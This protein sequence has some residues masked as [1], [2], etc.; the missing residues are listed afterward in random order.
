MKNIYIYGKNNIY[1]IY[2]RYPITIQPYKNLLVLRDDLLDGGTK[3]IFMPLIK[4]K[5]IKKYVYA[6]PVEG[7][8][9]L[10]LSKYFKKKCVIFVAKRKKIHDNQKEV[11]KNGSTVIQVPFGYLSNVQAKAKEYCN[12]NKKCK[13]IEWGG[14]TYIDAIT[15]RAKKVIKKTGKLDE[16]WCAIG[17][18]TLVQGIMKAVPKNTQ[19]YGVQVGAKYRGKK[20]KNLHII[21]YK[22]P[23]KYES[24]IKLPFQSNKNYDSKVFEIALKKAKGKALLWNVY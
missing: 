7:G 10:A 11:K 2:M 8:F 14:T 13:Y 17:S 20:Y 9:Q 15:K 21:K 18:G 4:Q 6:S 5:G 23:F 19:V 16:I 22:K 24:K 12:K 1:L 3:S